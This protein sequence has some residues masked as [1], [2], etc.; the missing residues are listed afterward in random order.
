MVVSQPIRTRF[1]VHLG[2]IALAS[3]VLGAA[4]PPAAPAAPAE[5]VLDVTLVPAAPERQP[6]T[7]RAAPPKAAGAHRPVA[8]RS[9]G[10]GIPLRV[11]VCLL[12]AGLA[13]LAWRRRPRRCPGCG[14]AMRRLSPTAAFAELD[15]GERTDQL[16]G[17][18]RYEVWRCDACGLVDKESLARDLSAAA[19]AAPPGSAIFL[20]RRAQS[21][22][23][24]WSPSRS[25]PGVPVAAAWKQAASPS[26]EAGPP[27]VSP[28]SAGE[29]GGSPD[30]P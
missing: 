14:T 7:P 28:A 10:L 8:A 13:W 9:S 1:L 27:T 24:I 5:R 25:L 18:V 15:M 6:T 16:V 17:D 23:S 20:R 29:T 3:T 4:P 2:V 30:E 11:A 21:G 12:G 26:P 22:L 19:A